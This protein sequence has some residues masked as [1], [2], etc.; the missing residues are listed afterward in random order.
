MFATDAET[1][2][3]AFDAEKTPQK[4]AA[5]LSALSNQSGVSAFRGEVFRNLLKALHSSETAENFA[6]MVLKAREDRRF[7]S[8]ALGKISVG[9]T[10]LVKGLEESGRTGLSKALKI[11]TSEPARHQFEA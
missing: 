5:L 4:A 1:A 10:L 2:A 11:L 9:S 7:H 6:D 3:L 8:R